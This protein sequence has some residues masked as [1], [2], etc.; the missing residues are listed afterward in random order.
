MTF[1]RKFKLF[2]E[3]NWRD[4]LPG[5]KEVFKLKNASVVM[6][7]I[8]LGIPHG[9][10]ETLQAAVLLEPDPEQGSRK[11]HTIRYQLKTTVGSRKIILKER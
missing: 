3:R 2:L 7:K 10:P 8:F 5:A 1:A 9:G 11:E 4:T 6:G